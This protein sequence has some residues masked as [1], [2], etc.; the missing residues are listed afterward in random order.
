[1]IELFRTPDQ[2]GPIIATIINETSGGND[3][4]DSNG[5]V[6]GTGLGKQSSAITTMGSLP[7]AAG[8][9]VFA[10]HGAL[11]QGLARASIANLLRRVD[12]ATPPQFLSTV[13]VAN[14]V[15]VGGNDYLGRNSPVFSSGQV[16]L[17]ALFDVPSSGDPIPVYVAGG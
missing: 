9:Y 6:V 7:F 10:T 11:P 13:W 5:S 15:S 2:L 16:I 1:M 8:D 4:Y 14:W 17:T 12:A 3:I